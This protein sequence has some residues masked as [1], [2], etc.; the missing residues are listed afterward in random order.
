[1]SLLLASLALHVVVPQVF[2][3]F[4]LSKQSPNYFPFDALRT[5]EWIGFRG[6]STNVSAT[7]EGREEHTEAGEDGG[8]GV[9]SLSKQWLISTVE[10]STLALGESQ[11]PQI[12]W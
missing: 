3:F 2:F 8:Q 9:F 11:W 5:T 1:M 4:F 7:D 10:E 6:T 12:D